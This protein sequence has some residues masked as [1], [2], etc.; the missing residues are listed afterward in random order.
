[1]ELNEVEA[2]FVHEQVPEGAVPLGLVGAIY[3]IDISGESQSVSYTNVGEIG[4][5]TALGITELLKFD[6]LGKYQCGPHDP[7]WREHE[8]LPGDEND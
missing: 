3:Y 4:A 8:H 6:L 7:W 1:M 2:A 5:A